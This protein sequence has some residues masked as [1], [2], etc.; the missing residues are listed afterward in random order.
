MT[1]KLPHYCNGLFRWF[2]DG[3]NIELFGFVPVRW[4][5]S[6]WNKARSIQRCWNV[7]CPTFLASW[8]ILSNRIGGLHAQLL[9]LDRYCTNFNGLKTPVHGYSRPTSADGRRF[10]K[11]VGDQI[12]LST[13]RWNNNLVILGCSAQY[14]RIGIR[15][16]LTV[17]GAFWK[18][19]Q[20]V[21]GLLLEAEHSILWQRRRQL[22]PAKLTP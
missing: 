4:I 17:G 11:D 19:Q 15:R 3:G 7:C 20:C 1:C 5:R 21:A 8:C 12:V 14:K 18:I 6:L 22:T 13:C 10:F 2:F 16:L 9:L